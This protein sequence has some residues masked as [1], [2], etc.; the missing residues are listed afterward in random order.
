MKAK[1]IRLGL[2]L[3]L[4]ALLSGCTAPSGSQD[5]QALEGELS[6]LKAQ[7]E[8][9]SGQVKALQDQLSQDGTGELAQQIEALKAQIDAL[10]GASGGSAGA[11]LRI[12][13]VNAEEVFVKYKGTEEAIQRY[14]QEKADKEQE[15]STL[16]DR[17]SAGAISQ[18]EYLSK[19]TELENALKTLDQ[20]LT[21]EITQKIVETV[22]QLGAELGY[23]LITSRKNV[24]LYYKD[25][26]IHDI[27]DKVLER[28]NAAFEGSGNG[29]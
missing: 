23:D 26:V 3:P 24:V 1:W 29:S 20:Q 6:Q 19:R 27:T 9:L 16:Q 15:L 25:G 10:Q 21:N 2:V 8:Q 12:A 22:D 7:V 11:Q 4:V 14:R 28:M 5:T 17:W 18:Q 13:F